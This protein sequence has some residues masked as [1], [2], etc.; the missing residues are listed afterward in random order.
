MVISRSYRFL[1]STKKHIALPTGPFRIIGSY[2]VLTGNG[3]DDGVFLRLL[4]PAANQ[5]INLTETSDRWLT[6]F[7][8][9]NYKI[10]YQNMGGGAWS[11][12]IKFMNYLLGESY[13]PVYANVMPFKS[14]KP[15][16][17][18]VF[19]H[20]IASCRSTYSALCLE[21]V[22]YGFVVAGNFAFFY[23][24]VFVTKNCSEF[25]SKMFA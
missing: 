22:S 8:D 18:V 12:V 3:K 13:L 25:F 6:W 2:D 23:F 10:G 15:Y 5:G 4:Y 17:V 16:P 9:D 14:E 24:I 11:P 21:L 20:G 1:N 7:P 19:S